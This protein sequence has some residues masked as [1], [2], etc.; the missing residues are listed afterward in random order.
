MMRVV[1]YR[2][3]RPIDWVS[4]KRMPLGPGEGHI[5]DRCGA[6]HAVVYE[7][8]DTET[9]K[10]YS[11]GST[12]AKHQF[13][14]E[15]DKDLE[16]KALVKAA[17]QIAADQ[18]DSLRHEMIKQATNEIL[19]RISSTPIPPFVMDDQRYQPRVTWVVGDS[20]AL[21]SFGRTAQE[22]QQIALEGW[23]RNRVRELL[24]VGWN[25]ADVRRQPGTRDRTT[26]S[27][28]QK[29][30]SDVMRQVFEQIRGQT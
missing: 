27:M 5:C 18:I 6:E 10:T 20:H 1:G 15:V 22:T 8:L 13:G 2:D 25:K 11:V 12:C 16:A 3:L 21:A 29:L 23:F 14:F 30:E 17:K 9:G 19:V 28:S 7:V 26:V 24:P 4:G